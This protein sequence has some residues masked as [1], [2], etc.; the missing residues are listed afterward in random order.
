[1]LKGILLNDYRI[2]TQLYSRTGRF[3]LE[4]IQNIEDCSFTHTDRPPTISFKVSPIEIV[5]E[6]NQDGFLERD[7]AGICRTGRSWKRGNS[8]YVGDKGIGFKSV[9][10]VASRVEIQSN[11]FSFSFEYDGGESAEERL[12]IV[13]PIVGDRP[14]PPGERPLTRMTLTKNEG[15]RYRNILFEFEALPKTLLLFLSKVKEIHFQ[16]DYL[17]PARTITRNFDITEEEIGTSCISMHTGNSNSREQW[18]YLVVKAPI[19]EL[20]DDPAR[21]GMNSCETVLAFPVDEHGLPSIRTGQDIYAFLPVCT[22]GFNV[23]SA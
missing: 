22:V 12:G 19:L 2:A 3:I 21:R 20:P 1:M 16:I 6:S 8:G 15:T 5:V 11:A 7:V 17:D 10:K 4:L 18:R 9:F 14:I 23:S 13:T